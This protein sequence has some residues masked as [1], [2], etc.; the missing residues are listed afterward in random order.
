MATAHNIKYIEYFHDILT[1]PVGALPKQETWI[2]AFDDLQTNILPAIK[3][4]LKYEP[5]ANIGSSLPWNIEEAASLISGDQYQKTGGCMVCQAIDLP[6]FNTN[7]I[8]DGNIQYNAFLR[9]YVGQGRADFPM[10]RMTFLDTIVSFADNFLRPWALATAQ[11]GLIAR[12]KNTPENYRTTM[13]CW[14]LGGI[15]SD[16]PPTIIKQF[17]F[18]ELCCISVNNE[19]LNYMGKT[20]PP[21]REAQFIYNYYTLKTSSEINEFITLSKGYTGDIAASSSVAVT[22]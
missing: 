5:G 9:S 10:L 13:N 7:V 17:T 20:T 14:Q 6:S 16:K 12:A 22:V 15:S 4:T 18:H 11:F 19:E 2:V 8:A 21:L 1:T 3:E